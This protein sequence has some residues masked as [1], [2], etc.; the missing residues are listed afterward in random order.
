MAQGYIFDFIPTSSSLYP[1]SDYNRSYIELSAASG[2]EVDYY[3]AIVDWNFVTPQGTMNSANSVIAF[4][5]GE[6]GLSWSWD[7]STI[8]FNANPVFNTR[9]DDA[10][11]SYLYNDFIQF[12]YEVAPSDYVLDN[13]NGY[14]QAAPV[15]EPSLLPLVL[16]CLG[17]VVLNRRGVTRKKD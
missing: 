1:T 4:V 10:I 6:N 14:W 11:Y 15:P 13:A 5:G 8:S 17:G 9:P 3:T 16:A 7:S 2:V 12:A